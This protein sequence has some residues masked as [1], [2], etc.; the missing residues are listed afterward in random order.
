MSTH[1]PSRICDGSSVLNIAPQTGH[2]SSVSTVSLIAYFA[3]L[4][5]EES[6]FPLT[7]ASQVVETIHLVPPSLRQRSSHSAIQRK[8]SLRPKIDPPRFDALLQTVEFARVS[9]FEAPLLRS[10]RHPLIRLLRFD[11]FDLS[12]VGEKSPW[13]FHAAM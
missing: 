9:L 4:S 8:P 11:F 7:R 1:S 12:L 2:V 5:K 6:L 3:V 10:Q 13:Y